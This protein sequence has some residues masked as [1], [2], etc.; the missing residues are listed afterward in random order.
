MPTWEIATHNI[1]EEHSAQRPFEGR[2]PTCD[3]HI[4]NC[5][6]AQF[7]EFCKEQQH[8]KANAERPGAPQ[9]PRRVVQSQLRPR[10][11]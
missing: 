8:L 5:Q 4:N 9:L 1:T 11:G 3:K 6:L 7:A 10:L 2:H